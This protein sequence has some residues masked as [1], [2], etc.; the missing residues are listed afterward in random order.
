LLE[1]GL[2]LANRFG[3][4]AEQLGQIRDTAQPQFGGFDGGIASS[5]FLA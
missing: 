4:D 3:I 1:I 2:S 5:I